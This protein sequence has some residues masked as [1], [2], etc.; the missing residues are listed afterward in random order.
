MI[1][2]IQTS[3]PAIGMNMEILVCKTRNFHQKSFEIKRITLSYAI[4]QRNEI[5]LKVLEVRRR[6]GLEVHQDGVKKVKFLE[7]RVQA[8]VNF[9]V[10]LEE[11]L[12]GITF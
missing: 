5:D 8:I 11:R 10:Q 4:N 6:M 7:Q 1:L 2:N 12:P 9:M 3:T